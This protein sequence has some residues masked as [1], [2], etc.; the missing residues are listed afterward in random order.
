MQM[1]E[2][3]QAHKDKLTAGFDFLHSK[4]KPANVRTA[5]KEICHLTLIHNPEPTKP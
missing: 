5:S 2:S 4:Q 3:D 1:D